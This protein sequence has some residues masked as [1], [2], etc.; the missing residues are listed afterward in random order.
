MRVAQII[1]GL[2]QLGGAEKLQ[3][4]LVKALE[5]KDVELTIITIGNDQIEA[6]REME[7]LGVRVV[8]FPARRFL[9]PLRALALRRFLAAERFDVVHTHLVRSTVLGA[10]AARSVGTPVIA[11]IH[12][13][14]RNPRVS[15]LLLAL[16]V[17]AVRHWVDHVLA[18]G[19]ETAVAHRE[20]FSGVEIEVLPNAV[21]TPVAIDAP[22]RRKVRD[23]LGID[24]AD[25]LCI[26]VGRL[27]PPKN[28]A[29]LIDAFAR[30]GATL[31]S[32]RLVIV[33]QGS[34]EE[35]LEAQVISLGL[36][37]QVTFTGLRGD[38]DRLLASSDI[39]V[40]SSDSEGLPLATLE[41]MHAA[42]PVVATRIGDV[43]RVVTAETGRLV[44]RR[45]LDGL[46]RE[47][48]D[49]I[50]DEGLRISL[51]KAGR[52]RALGVFG[53]EQWADKHMALYEELAGRSARPQM[54][55][56]SKAAEEDP[57]C[58]S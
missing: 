56:T 40:S 5:P 47:I 22:E 19:W 46:A 30:V 8:R 16:E 1:D 49:L 20:R 14:K 34:M 15:R 37:R 3:Q 7:A 33:G 35:A 44:E 29:L 39:Y 27:A 25:C 24:E 23:E 48:E 18:V 12:S 10:A 13:A 17:H 6:V 2:R 50:E 26:A 52:E 51:G 54:A 43:P 28:F 4:T 41:A 57:P 11:T 58:V 31:P 21:E 42:L 55:S 36:E 53:V 38:V 9:S 32:A 45:D